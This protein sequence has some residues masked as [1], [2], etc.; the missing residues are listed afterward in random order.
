MKHSQTQSLTIEELYGELVDESNSLKN[1][2]A[3]VTNQ[4]TIFESELGRTGQKIRE[5]QAFISN[6]EALLVETKESN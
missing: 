2:L 6:L 3:R 1:N 5:K 4:N